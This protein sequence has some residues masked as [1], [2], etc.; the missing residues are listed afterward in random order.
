MCCI[1]FFL[2]RI[3]ATLQISAAAGI[4]IQ[5]N[6]IR[7]KKLR[8]N[9]PNTASNKFAGGSPKDEYQFLNMKC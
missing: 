1:S 7:L 9:E 4:V 2:I 5:A 8:T 6:I 3:H